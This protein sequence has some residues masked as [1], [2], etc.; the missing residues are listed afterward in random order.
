[1]STYA[2]TKGSRECRE[3]VVA[4]MIRLNRIAPTTEIG[5]EA[6]VWRTNLI[7]ESL[8]YQLL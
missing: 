3:K 5:R 4:D 8:R 2:I 1:V 6:S 7:I